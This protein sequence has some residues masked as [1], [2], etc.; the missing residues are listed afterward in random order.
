MAAVGSVASL[1]NTTLHARAGIIV[2]CRAANFVK[3]GHPQT[4]LEGPQ[5]NIESTA[6]ASL[7]PPSPTEMIGVVGR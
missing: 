4:V 6:F 1:S 7:Y 2:T 5:V 3:L